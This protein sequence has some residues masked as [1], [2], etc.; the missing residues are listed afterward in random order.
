MFRFLLIILFPTLVSAQ[1]F[2]KNKVQYD[3]FRWRVHTTPHFEIFF[4]EDELAIFAATVLEQELER[5]TSIFGNVPETRSPVIIYSSHNDFKQTNVILNIIGEGVGGFAEMTKNRIVLPFTGSYED[6]RH[7]LTHELVH[8]LQF[9]IDDVPLLAHNPIHRIPLWYLEGMAEYFALGEDPKTDMVIRDLVY[10]GRVIPIEEIWRIEGTYLMYKQGQSILKFIADRYGEEKIAEIYHNMGFLEGFDGALRQTL[11]MDEETLSEEWIMYIS[12]EAWREADGRVASPE[13]SRR[14]TRRDGT[15]TF[16]IAPSVSP[17]GSQFVFMSDRDQYGSIYLASAI[18]GDIRRR[19]VQSGKTGLFEGIYIMEGNISWT[20]D[21]EKIVFV[22]KRGGRDVINIMD[23]HTS[24]LV[25]QI[26]PPPPTISSPVVSPDGRTIVFRGVRGARADIYITDIATGKTIQLTDDLYD[27][28]TP[29]ISGDYIFFASDRPLEE[30]E[31]RYGNYAIY[32]MRT[33]G[34][35]L[36]KITRGRSRETMLPLLKSDTLLYYLANYSNITDLYLVN[37]NSNEERQLTAVMGGIE[38]YT[39]SD[40]GRM[41]FS[42]YMD[43]GWDIFAMELPIDTLPR[44]KERIYDIPFV[45]VDTEEMEMGIEAEEPGLRFAPDFA[46]GTVSIIDGNLRANAQIA[47]SD[48]LGNHRLH[49]LTDHPGD[50]L[51]SNFHLSYWYLERRLNLGLAVVREEYPRLI[52]RDI[53][54]GRIRDILFTERSTSAMVALEY[55]FDKFKRLDGGLTFSSMERVFYK[56]E[57]D[58]WKE[59]ESRKNYITAPSLS[60]VFDNT[61]WGAMGPVNGTRLRLTAAQAIPFTRRCL[62]Y[63]YLGADIRRYLRIYPGYSFAVRMF[64]GGLRTEDFSP[65]RIGGTGSIRGYDY[66]QFAGDNIGGFNLELRFPFI[67]HLR[68][69]FPL[70]LE[71]HGIRGALFLDGGYAIDRLRDLRLEDI[72]MGVGAGIRMRFPQF[73][74]LFDMARKLD[75]ISG[76]TRYH[77]MLGTEF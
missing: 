22:S 10:Y 12:K 33:E 52:F 50:I 29:T 62:S 56:W 66:L 42:L 71:I 21:G 24:H 38:S 48:I 70:P 18:T 58:E 2:G 31:W 19:V 30:E 60:F 45:A 14:L 46:G 25:Q 16:N 1:F 23:P 34:T 41:L 59:I 65:L 49:L 43:R 8:I 28:R 4:Y 67:K 72:K 39:V 32:K 63:S 13:G 47:V 26:T 76:E 68:L 17:D 55:P 3:D 61:L 35:E 77:I 54:D 37:L 64:A 5:I 44:S 9:T 73:V 6:L 40:N 57:Q 51:R 53:L 7:V 74:L 11:G 36:Q 75:D 27:D 20:P 15:Y 69:G